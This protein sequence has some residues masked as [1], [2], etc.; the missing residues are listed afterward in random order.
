MWGKAGA[1]RPTFGSS[2][3]AR[4]EEAIK[5]RIQYPGRYNTNSRLETPGRKDFP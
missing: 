2:F 3:S 4:H 5:R 1:S